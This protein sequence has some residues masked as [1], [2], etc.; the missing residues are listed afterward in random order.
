L[1][2]ILFALWT[3][4]IVFGINTEKKIEIFLRCLL[5]A[6]ILYALGALVGARDQLGRM[7]AFGGGPNVFV[8][9]IGMGIIAIFYFWIKNKKTIWIYFIPGLLGIAIMS[10]SRGGTIALLFTLV[11]ISCWL[12]K[13]LRIQRFLQ[14]CIVL[15]LISLVVYNIPTINH[16]FY[17]FMFERYY[18]LT[19]V[20][21]YT[22]I[23]D[24][25]F[26]EA[27]DMFLSNPLFG[28]GFKG[29]E[30]LTSTTQRYSHNLLLDLAA[31]GG[32]A[33]LSL[34]FLVL[35]LVYKRWFKEKTL[36]NNIA[37]ILS[38]FIFT[39]SL[40][41]GDIYDTRFM[42][43]FLSFYMMPVK[44]FKFSSNAGSRAV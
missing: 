9:V 25:L 10:G 34:F 44:I 22:S 21:H 12:I 15:F 37:I 28:I 19:F 39:A 5:F 43:I 6:S 14:F 40:F 16:R 27:W 36:E 8:R 32:V 29:F 3:L 26:A 13:N 7:S 2:F 20:D 24:I 4:P 18:Q 35:M 1:L 17:S 11:V 33:A 30:I 23:R 42:W 31:E 41:S 38:L